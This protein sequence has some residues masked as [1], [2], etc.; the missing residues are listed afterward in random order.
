MRNYWS[1]SD[2]ERQFS[3]AFQSC[4]MLVQRKILITKVWIKNKRIELLLLS[5]KILLYACPKCFL[6]VQRNFL[7]KN[8]KRISTFLKS[9]SDFDE[10]NCPED[11]QNALTRVQSKLF[12][13][14]FTQSFLVH[15]NFLDCSEKNLDFDFKN[16]KNLDFL[17]IL[18]NTVHHVCLKVHYRVLR[19]VYSKKIRNF[20]KIQETFHGL[21][22]I[23]FGNVFRSALNM[24]AEAIWAAIYFFKLQ[25]LPQ[26]CAQSFG[27]V[28]KKAIFLYRKKNCGILKLKKIQR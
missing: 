19:S 5:S 4:K 3:H 22:A 12:K 7:R 14:K 10:K 28:V 8:R 9:N 20:F 17:R 15:E 26:F 18:S 25:V 24:S 1:F 11:Q 27:T 6:R 23:F 13:K 21:P 16:F 2:F